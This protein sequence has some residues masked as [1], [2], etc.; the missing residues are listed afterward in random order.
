LL[1][2]TRI[3]SGD[4]GGVAVAINKDVE[5]GMVDDQGRQATTDS[6]DNEIKKPGRKRAGR[7]SG[8]YFG[9]NKAYIT[10]ISGESFT[11]KVVAFSEVGKTIRRAYYTA[12]GLSG[13]GILY[14]NVTLPKD[15]KESEIEEAVKWRFYD[16]EPAD[17]VFVYKRTGFSPDENISILCVAVPRK[18]INEFG[19]KNDNIYTGLDL[20]SLALWNGYRL[21]NPGDDALILIMSSYDGVTVV[22]GRSSVEF[23]R[24]IPTSLNI[25]F[26]KTRS[27]DYFK[28]TY[29]AADADIVELD[30]EQ[31]AWFISTG[32]ALS[33]N[34]PEFHNLLPKQYSRARTLELKKPRRKELIALACICLLLL[35]CIPFALSFY[36][37][38]EVGKCHEIITKNTPT[39]EQVMQTEEELRKYQEWVGAVESFLTTPYTL[40]INNVRHATPQDITLDRLELVD[41]GQWSNV[42]GD[43]L[44]ENNSEGGEGSKSVEQSGSQTK[45][46]YKPNVIKVTGKSLNLGAIGLFVDNLYQLPFIKNTTVFNAEYSDDYY[47]FTLEA[48]IKERY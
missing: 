45:A 18:M 32:Y 38:R 46:L 40:I 11:R 16:I 5:T 47:N 12:T 36:Y 37:K 3:S 33:H 23:V 10:N 44:E 29:D 14:K 19:E 30:G 15:I 2:E 28:R 26:E 43:G 31:A 6:I 42:D 27:I 48:Y 7:A 25:D 20:K 39:V 21:S 4:K 22:C 34:D 8:V 1:L 35:S 9:L 17:Y 41:S 13:Q 24:E